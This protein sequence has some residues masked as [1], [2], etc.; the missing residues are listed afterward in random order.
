MIFLINIGNTHTQL[1][2]HDGKEVSAIT[3]VKTAELNPGMVP[4]GIPVAAASVVPAAKEKLAGK[5]IFWVNASV[6][7]GLD[8]SRID[9]N[10]IGADRVANVAML[11]TMAKGPATCIDFGTAVTFEVIDDGIFCGGYILP[12]R[13]LLRRSL[14]DY[15][16]QLPL[17][18]LS[19]VLPEEFA[20]T[21]T[22]RA[23]RLGV[24][25]GAI[26]A[27]SGL[28]ER[29]KKLFSSRAVTFVGVG[30]DRAFFLGQLAELKD[31]GDLFTLEGIKKI[32]EINN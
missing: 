13:Q 9:R 27:V 3:T 12:G 32:W 6:N 23:M 24:D 14:H 26:G 4:D 11:A 2:H 18:P 22:E 17:L 19:E 16:A 15:T 30:G 5:S 8:F 31:G 25:G 7:S 20:G 28:M 10:T 29:V 1:A 21:N